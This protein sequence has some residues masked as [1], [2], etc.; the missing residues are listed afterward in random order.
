MRVAIQLLQ[1][2]SGLFGVGMVVWAFWYFSDRREAR[3]QKRRGGT[4]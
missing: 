4:L 2:F 3:L 1:I